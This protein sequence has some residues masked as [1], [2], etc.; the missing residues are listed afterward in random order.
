MENQRS[1]R[2]YIFVRS[3]QLEGTFPGDHTVGNWPI[4]SLRI[5]RGWGS[6]REE[7]WPYNGEASA[8]PPIEPPGLDDLAKPFRSGC[9]Q[10]V[11]TPLEC[12]TVLAKEQ[13]VL[14]SLDITDKWATAPNGR[15]PPSSPSDVTIGSHAVVLVGYD[16]RSSEF[17]FQ[18]S[19]GKKWGDQGYGYIPYEVFEAT[20]WEGWLS[21]LAGNEIPSELQ[22]GVVERTW[23]VT[24]HGGGVLHCCEFV[25]AADERIAWAFAVEREGGVEVEELFVR[26]QFR[27]N[28][29]GRRLGRYLAKLA[30]ERGK[31][32][33]IWISYA[34]TG[35]ENLRVIGKLSDEIGIRLQPSSVRWAP[36]VAAAETNANQVGRF[37]TPAPGNR[38][39]SPFR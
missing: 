10:R 23:G 36:Y 28:G 5:L 21:D 14:I 8:W 34:D 32:L 39:R 9:Y 24:E 7:F 13:P 12:K 2:M 6:P 20:W 37:G 31:H 19:W 1:S 33:R 35:A 16:D 18:N 4:T 38:P 30:R 25:N 29:Y 26:P 22:F 17:M 11:R 3:R 15:I 27:R